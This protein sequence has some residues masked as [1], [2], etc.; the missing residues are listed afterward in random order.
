MGMVVWD[1]KRTLVQYHLLDGLSVGIT[2]EEEGGSEVTST[3]L[4]QSSVL[5]QGK[6]VQF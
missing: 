1:I 2:G 3:D 6:F 5:D 4:S